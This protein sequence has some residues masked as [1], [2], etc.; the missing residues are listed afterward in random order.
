LGGGAAA[1]IATNQAQ[2]LKSTK[3]LDGLSQGR[4]VLGRIRSTTAWYPRK[5]AIQRF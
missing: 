2:R 5:K 1:I 3:Y 4:Y